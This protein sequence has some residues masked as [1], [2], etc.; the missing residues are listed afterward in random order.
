MS[1]VDPSALVAEALPQEEVAAVSS[2]QASRPGWSLPEAIGGEAALMALLK[3][4][5]DRLYLDLMVGFLFEP[6]DKATLIAHQYSYVCA[7]LG[8]RAG[9]YQ[10]RSMRGAHQALPLLGAHFDRRHVILKQVMEAHQVPA[11]VK[12]AWL[13]L[14]QRL[15]PFIVRQGATARAK[16]VA[17]EPA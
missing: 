3:D 17:G 16:I 10:G 7:Y 15:R 2:T 8:D 9:H 1:E 5:Y 12:Q 4:F 11:H 6:H 14:E 13:E